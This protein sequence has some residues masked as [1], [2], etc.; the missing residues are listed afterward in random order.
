MKREKDFKRNFKESFEIKD[1]Y[2]TLFFEHRKRR[3]ENMQ[4]EKKRKMYTQF[5][6]KNNIFVDTSKQESK[7]G[8]TDF[9]ERRMKKKTKKDI[10]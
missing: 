9:L 3:K 6:R 5:V 8:D 4:K 1:D 2:L 7:K 10:F